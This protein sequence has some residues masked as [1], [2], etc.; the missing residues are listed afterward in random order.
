MSEQSLQGLALVGIGLGRDERRQASSL[1]SQFGQGLAYDGR[2]IQVGIR[3]PARVARGAFDIGFARNDLR[4]LQ[5][6]ATLLNDVAVTNRILG[7]NIADQLLL[8]LAR[9]R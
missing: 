5:Q 2:Q 6:P 3:A 1:A 9:D 4:L 7:L 8:K